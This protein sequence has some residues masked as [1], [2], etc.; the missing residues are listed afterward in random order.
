MRREVRNDSPKKDIETETREPIPENV[1]II[2]DSEEKPEDR[3]VN[4]EP[5]GQKYW[6]EFSFYVLRSKISI[7]FKNLQKEKADVL[8]IPCFDKSF[9]VFPGSILNASPFN[10]REK[11]SEK[12]FYDNNK[13]GEVC[14]QKCVGIANFNIFAFINIGKVTNKIE[15]CV[16]NLFELLMRLKTPIKEVVFPFSMQM[17][18]SLLPILARAVKGL[19]S[20]KNSSLTRLT[21]ITK[22]MD[23][24][25][26]GVNEFKTYV[27]SL[28]EEN[29]ISAEF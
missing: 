9:K 20:M 25:E 3:M 22:D 2:I 1:S 18:S 29:E 10:Y 15:K 8:V 6:P 13:A 4:L 21:I 19:E 26:Q 11:L 24:F 17:N 23:A 14:L 12:N 28:I 7:T 27:L 5:E 16:E